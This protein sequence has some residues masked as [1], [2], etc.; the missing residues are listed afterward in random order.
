VYLYLALFW[1]GVGIILQVFWDGISEF[2]HIPVSRMVVGLFCF[3][4]MSY[5]S[6]RWRISHMMMNAQRKL[7]EPK[8]YARRERGEYDPN[9]DF[10]KMDSDK[11]KPHD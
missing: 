5:N 3:V 10:T 6:T 9:L 7:D 1:L 11:P 4:L 8:P 2:A